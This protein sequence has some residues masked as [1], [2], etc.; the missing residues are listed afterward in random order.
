MKTKI[1]APFIILVV[2]IVAVAAGIIGYV[3]YRNAGIQKQFAETAGALASMNTS[4][5]I[6]NDSISTLANQDQNFV[7]KLDSNQLDNSAVL[8]QI[9]KVSATVSSID[10]LSKTDPQ[11]LQKYSK[12]YFLNEHYV[13]ASLSVIEPQYVYD[14]ARSYQIHAQVLPHLVKMI[15]A[16]RSAGKNILVASSYR[17]FGTQTALKQ[18]YKVTY[19]AGTANSF[20]A[21]QGYSEHQLGTTVDL[22]TPLLGATFDAFDGTA[23]FAWLKEHAHEYGFILSYPQSNTYYKYEPWHWRYVGVDLASRLHREGKYFYDYD[24]RTI[25]DYLLTI[26]D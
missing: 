2:A 23:E 4:I 25:N 6:L 26:F 9:N 19:G 20:S 14:K 5:S 8:D 17:S 18:N 11:L 10:K 24:Q 1:G 16:A 12:V 13:P 21:D 7:Q 3:E 15:D 22:T